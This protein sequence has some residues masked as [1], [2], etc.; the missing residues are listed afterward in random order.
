[1]ASTSEFSV[2]LEAFH[3]PLDL[4]LFLIR[5]SEVQISDI[6]V[7]QI[8]DQYLGILH[9]RDG[10]DLAHLD[11]ELAG[12]FLVMAATLME[13][14]SRVLA[15][16]APDPAAEPDDQ[17]TGDH[18]AGARPTRQDPP[19]P[20]AELVKQLLAYKRLRDAA[21]ALQERLARWE[22]RFAAAPAAAPPAPDR[23]HAADALTTD[24]AP[25]DPAAAEHAAAAASEPIELDDLALTDLWE[26]FARIIATVDLSRL[27]QHRVIDE[28]VPLAVHAD[29]L[30]EQLRGRALSRQGP[31]E[32][33]AALAGRT[34][35]EAIGLFLAL[36]ELMRQG[37]VA[38][39][40]D[41]AQDTISI[42]LAPPDAPTIDA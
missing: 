21:G 1:M 22:G 8:T 27:G 37:R 10:Q 5:R 40:Q 33:R 15:P 19:D 36:L 26:A 23:P 18:H 9:A 32:L 34:R 24:A 29:E 42:A 28:E 30:L 39:T 14:K 41:R 16:Q 2:R 25:A 20:R 6:P 38:V 11:I 31:I 35:G 12:E 7:A 13:L 3:G 4:L 17:A